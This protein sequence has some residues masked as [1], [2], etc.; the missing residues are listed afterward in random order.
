MEHASIDYKNPRGVRLC[1]HMK[2]NCSRKKEIATGFCTLLKWMTMM[3]RTNASVLAE[4][5]RVTAIDMKKVGT[6]ELLVRS[7]QLL[8][9]LLSVYASED[10]VFVLKVAVAGIQFI[11][12]HD[13]DDYDRGTSISDVSGRCSSSLRDCSLYAFKAIAKKGHGA[14]SQIEMLLEHP[15]LRAGSPIH[16]GLMEAL[17]LSKT[18]EERFDVFME[19]GLLVSAMDAVGQMSGQQAERIQRV[20]KAIKALPD[21]KIRSMIIELVTQ[22]RRELIETYIVSALTVNSPLRVF[23]ITLFPKWARYRESYT[24]LSENC[25]NLWAKPS[26][27]VAVNCLL[28]L[29]Q[30]SGYM[31]SAQSNLQVAD[32]FLGK[33]PYRP[34]IVDNTYATTS[35]FHKAASICLIRL[36]EGSDEEQAQ[37]VVHLRE[38]MEHYLLWGQKQSQGTFFKSA[39]SRLLAF[40]LRTNKDLSGWVDPLLWESAAGRRLWMAIIEVTS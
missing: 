33:D 28:G 8:T 18:A 25:T 5:G 16:T 37:A 10:Y 22:W 21:E 1:F 34:F 27:E 11:L 14:R 12:N 19:N 39:L 2:F 20:S 7:P 17:T 40:H 23:H 32:K 4:I 15:N 31:Y 35:K 6:Q 3:G 13:I 30:N 29:S 9:H 26:G 24:K 36:M 38:L